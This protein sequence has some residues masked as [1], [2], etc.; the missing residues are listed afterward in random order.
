MLVSLYTVRVVLATLGAE[1]YGIYN[2]VAG[3]VVLFSFVNNAM[4]TATQRF[5]NYNLGKEDVEK[6]QQTFSA[7]LLIHIGISI[8]FVILAETIGLWFVYSKLNVP[9]ER[10]NA[11]MWCYQF[12]IVTTIFN[13]LRVPYNA[14]IIAYEKMSFFAWISI[15]EGFLKLFV[16][17]LLFVSSSD[18]LIMYACLLSCVSLVILF[19]YIYYCVIKFPHIQFKKNND[20]KNIYELLGFSG[21]SL[22]GA[23][24]NVANQHGTNIVFNIF[25]HVTVNAAMGIATQVNSA[26]YS[27]VGNFQTAFQP[28]LVKSYAAGE[29]DKLNDL[30]FTTAKI[31]FILLW[32][33]ALPLT[34]NLDYILVLW[35]KHVPLHTSE[36]I[37]LILIYSL[38]DSFNNPL[39]MYVQATGKIKL[40]QICVS[41]IIMSLLPFSILIFL[42][43]GDIYDVLYTK[44]FL[45]VIV[46]LFR[47]SY[48]RNKQ[49]FSSYKFFQNVIFRCLVMALFSYLVV[50]IFVFKF[51]GI[52]LLCISCIVSVILVCLFS[53]C[54]AMTKKERKLFINFLK[55]KYRRNQC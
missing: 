9:P 33:I 35:L 51:E 12:S 27:F 46:T 24:A 4:A 29:I 3:V 55:S 30:I 19:S 53:F 11:A 7:S 48:L 8:I 31:S 49:N 28:Q 52:I 37:H 25:T 10:H 14:V 43:G 23:T 38:I 36:I 22:L 15:V 13:I 34:I 26:V 2:V 18:K 17:Y 6:T 42:L 47:L 54:V 41:I 40:Y 39:W 16:V 21:W 1:D 45:V 20:K 32:T 50:K 44:I 5:L